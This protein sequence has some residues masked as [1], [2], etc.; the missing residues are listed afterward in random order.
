[1]A[2]CKV[3]LPRKFSHPGAI[4]KTIRYLEEN[5]IRDIPSIWSESEWLKGE[6]FLIIDSENRGTIDILTMT[7]NSDFGLVL[8]NE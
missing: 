5:N 2:G 8:L 1:M 7:Y 3:A 4:D 6:L